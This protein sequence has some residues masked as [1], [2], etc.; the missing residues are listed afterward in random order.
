MPYLRLTT[1]FHSI[2]LVI[3]INWLNEF[4]LIKVVMT[5]K[6]VIFFVEL[7]NVGFASLFWSRLRPMRQNTA[8]ERLTRLH[9]DFCIFAATI[10]VPAILKITTSHTQNLGRIPT[11]Y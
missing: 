3:V 5:V 7:P 2:L 1:D 9:E 11:A 4:L 6:F 8:M 10:R